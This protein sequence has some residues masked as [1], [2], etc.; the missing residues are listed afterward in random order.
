M[1][2]EKDYLIENLSLLISSGVDINSALSAIKSELRSKSAKKIIDNLQSGI[3]DGLSLSAALEKSHFLSSQNISLIKIGEASGKLP[4]NLK[5]ITIAL[6][7]E[8]LFRSKIYSAMIYPGIVFSLTLT[9]GLGISWFLLPRLAMTFSQLKVELP[10]LTKALIYFGNFL[11]SYGIVAVPAF[12]VL[13]IAF[14]YIYGKRLIFIIPGV[15]RIIQDV[16]IARMGFVVGTLLDAGLPVV[17]ALDSLGQSQTFPAYHK[18]YLHLKERVDEGNS[19]EKSFSSYPGISR[20]IPAPVRQIIIAAEKSGKLP[21]V[22]TK[23]GNDYEEKTDTT[24]KNLSVILEP[25]LLVIVWLGVVAVALAI[26]LPIYSLI[27][28]LNP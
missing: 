3:D 23:I 8:R 26:I 1:E 14:I 28:G 2:N 22:F 4:E 20:L 27:G 18:F 9:V 7:K 16:E 10:P 24:T 17:S 25:I 6:Q 21:E 11:G 19:F 15:R 12:L 13:F 5:V